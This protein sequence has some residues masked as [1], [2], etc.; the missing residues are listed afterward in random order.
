MVD[1]TLGVFW[2]RGSRSLY[3]NVMF[4]TFFRLRN[5]QAKACGYLKEICNVGVNHQKKEISMTKLIVKF[6]IIASV[7]ISTGNTHADGPPIEDGQISVPHQVITL[8]AKQIDQAG[9]YRYVLLDYEQRE[10]LHKIADADIPLML[11]IITAPYNDCTCG[12]HFYGLWAANDEVQ[13]SN[14]LLGYLKKLDGHLED[15]EGYQ[16]PEDFKTVEERMSYR[17]LNIDIYGN[18]YQKGVKVNNLIQALDVI[19]NQPEKDMWGN[20]IYVNTPPLSKSSIPTIKNVYI[21]I[22]DF[23]SKEGFKIFAYFENEYIGNELSG[24]NRL[25]TFS[26]EKIDQKIEEYKNGCSILCN[27]TWNIKASSTG[28]WKNDTYDVSLLNDHLIDTAWIEGVPGHGINEKIT[29]SHFKNKEGKPV[30]LNGFLLYN[31]F[32]KSKDL[33]LKNSRV[34]SFVLCLNNRPMYLLKLQD[35]MNAQKITFPEIKLKSMDEIML[36]IVDIYGGIQYQDTAISLLF[37]Y[38]EKK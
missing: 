4:C 2:D 18:V 1:V 15:L 6:I 29:F 12:M 9:Q 31:G 20:Y 7:L 8:S 24:Y 33:F 35:V 27:T 30:L 32:Q 28:R 22:K 37:P 38:Y 14:D 21:N 25:P 36:K 13:I 23:F 11:E 19:K 10:K 34:R 17:N 26:A 16:P 5:S 3:K